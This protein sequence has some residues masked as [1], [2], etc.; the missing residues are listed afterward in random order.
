MRFSCPLFVRLSILLALIWGLPGAVLAQSS[1]T[2][3]EDAE[4]G[5]NT[6][7]TR[8]GLRWAD[9]AFPRDLVPSEARLAAVDDAMRGPKETLQ[10]ADFWVHLSNSAPKLDN[11]GQLAFLAAGQA[12]EHLGVGAEVRYRISPEGSAEDLLAE[13]GEEMLT[14]EESLP[15]LDEP[16]RA[17]FAQFALNLSHARGLASSAFEEIDE[18]ERRALVASLGGLFFSADSSLAGR[19]PEGVDQSPDDPLALASKLLAAE[20]LKREELARATMAILVAV[21]SFLD[22]LPGPEPGIGWSHDVPGVS[23]LA[24]GPFPTSAGMLYLGGPGR[25]IWRIGEGII[26]DFDGD[27]IYEPVP[28][29]L[30]YSGG[31][32][33]M[34]IVD[35]RGDDT[36]RSEAWGQTGAA[37]LGLSILRD[38]EGNDSYEGT[39]LSQGAAWV[40]AGLLIDDQGD[41]VYRSTGL[42]QGAGGVGIGLLVDGAGTDL[43]LAAGRAQGFGTTL[44]VGVLADGSGNDTYR[45]S[46]TR[47]HSLFGMTQ[48]AGMG[49]P[50]GQIAGGVGV[51]WDGLGDDAYVAGALGQGAATWYSLGLLVEGAGD[52][53]LSV[54]QYGQGAAL[55]LAA[56]ALVD[57]EGDDRRLAGIGPAQGAAHDLALGILVDRAGNDVSIAGS[58][59]LGHASATG[60]GLYADLAG[61]DLYATLHEDHS[62]GEASPARGSGSWGLFLD[63]GGQ[64]RY[65]ETQ[66]GNDRGWSRGTWGG[67]LDIKSGNAGE[68]PQQ[69]R[70]PAPH[71]TACR[72][73]EIE[74]LAAADHDA[75]INSLL[76]DSEIWVR[77]EAARALGRSNASS[78]AAALVALAMGPDQAIVRG[79]AS[80]ALI[81]HDHHSS[82]EALSSALLSCADPQANAAGCGFAVRAAARILELAEEDGDFKPLREA[83]DKVAAMGSPELSSLVME[84]VY[85]VEFTP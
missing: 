40:G 57:L 31:A 59:G 72:H 50:D 20:G 62:L 74:K 2:W 73:A 23:G 63:L 54:A 58:S 79:A 67:G 35:F 3:P 42:S 25:N 8:L 34:T 15:S 39:I 65:A 56:A 84:L 61:Q 1:A 47:G 9:L 68:N 21:D 13:L 83:L 51:L 14:F 82:A 17:A 36:Y 12:C 71:P 64:D 69:D 45:A 26:I 24:Q 7:L 60:V 66:A 70:L 29:R 48:G 44:G 76:D 41:D 10:Q 80:L 38:L 43:Y 4:A 22:L 85:G 75:A 27:D 19:P 81:E 49:F 55:E 46:A 5:L 11:A 32:G 37:I 77:V 53:S 16:W 28:A 52:D 78:A 6:L 33:L 18:D 30:P